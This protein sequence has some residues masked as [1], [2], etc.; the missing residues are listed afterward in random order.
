V[1]AQCPI[2]MTFC[3]GI[4]SS[5]AAGACIRTSGPCIIVHIIPMISE[6]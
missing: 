5:K 6:I 4:F 3:N 2:V 1:A